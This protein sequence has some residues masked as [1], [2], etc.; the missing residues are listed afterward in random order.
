MYFLNED[1]SKTDRLYLILL[2]ISVCFT[3]IISYLNDREQMLTISNSGLL[4]EDISFTPKFPKYSFL[5][6]I[7][8]VAYNPIQPLFYSKIL[9]IITDGITIIFFWLNI[10]KKKKQY[11]ASFYS[12][13]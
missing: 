5:Y 9:W 7:I 2:K 11:L 6:I 10:E 8:A 4:I 3:A 13:T 1:L 12:D